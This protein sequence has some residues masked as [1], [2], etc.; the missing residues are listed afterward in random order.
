MF[1]FEKCAGFCA[2]FLFLFSFIS[3]R[4]FVTGDWWQ[5][6]RKHSTG[7]ITFWR[8]VRFSKPWLVPLTRPITYTLIATVTIPAFSLWICLVCG[9]SDHNWQGET[10]EDLES[11]G[12]A[13]IFISCE[14]TVVDNSQYWQQGQRNSSVD[15][16]QVGVKNRVYIDVIVRLLNN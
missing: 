6:Y 11:T 14:E 3:T 7:L 4:L 13:L 10:C 5:I 16:K 8:M 2:R 9:P 15:D 1:G 12:F